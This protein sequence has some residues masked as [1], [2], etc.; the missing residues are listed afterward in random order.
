MKE[1]DLKQLKVRLFCL[2][3]NSLTRFLDMTTLLNSDSSG[4]II[5]TL[6]Q[7]HKKFAWKSIKLL[8]C[9]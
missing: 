3:M 2:F 8:C 9:F 7:K 1:S 5:P 6:H 4:K